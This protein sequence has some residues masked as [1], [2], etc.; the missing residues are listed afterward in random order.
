MDLARNYVDAAIAA[1]VPLADRQRA[2]VMAAYMKNH[3]D[4]LGIPAPARRAAIK[5]LARPDGADVHEIVRRLWLRK[6]REYHY[7]ALDLLDAMAKRLN[8][9]ATI[10]LIEDLVLENCWWDSV[11]GF[12][13]IASAILRH[14]VDL[15]DGV[16]RWSAHPCY[17]MNRLAILHQK[18]W[19]HDTDS[20]ILF[21]LCRTHCANREFFIRKA[22]GWALRDYA[23]VNPPAVRGFVEQNRDSLSPLTVREAL[24]NVAEAGA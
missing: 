7:V 5:P 21:Q 1:L 10:A 15:R 8:P 19:G 9:S 4:F 6:E 17:W 18:G 12:A 16:W 11:D 14:N 3:F 20:A 2:A 24:K 23:R 22:I 13:A